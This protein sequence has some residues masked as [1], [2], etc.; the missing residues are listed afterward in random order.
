MRRYPVAQWQHSWIV[1]D[2]S[3]RDDLTKL[4]MHGNEGWELVSVQTLPHP[5]KTMFVMFFK[6]PKG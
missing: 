5:T 3:E 6:R 4:E 1:V 2:T